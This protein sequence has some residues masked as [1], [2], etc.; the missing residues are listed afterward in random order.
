M[1]NIYDQIFHNAYWELGDGASDEERTNHAKEVMG[2]AWNADQNAYNE[3]NSN[4]SWLQNQQQNEQLTQKLNLERL[5]RWNN[6]YGN[7]GERNEEKSLKDLYEEFYS[8]N[9]KD[10]DTS[11]PIGQD[12]TAG[13]PEVHSLGSFRDETSDIRNK[14]TNNQNESTSSI[15]NENQSHMSEDVNRRRYMEGSDID[16]ARTLRWEK[17]NDVALKNMIDRGGDSAQLASEIGKLNYNDDGSFNVEWTPEDQMTDRAKQFM[18]DKGHDLKFYYDPDAGGM[19]SADDVM[20]YLDEVTKA[21][22]DYYNTLGIQNGGQSNYWAGN[23]LSTQDR[24]NQLYQ[25]FR[26]PSNN[27]GGYGD[28]WKSLERQGG[29]TEHYGDEGARMYNDQD[30][31]WFQQGYHPDTKQIY[32]SL[33]ASGITKGNPYQSLEEYQNEHLREQPVDPTDIFYSQEPNQGPNAVVKNFT[34]GSTKSLNDLSYWLTHNTM[35]SPLNNGQNDFKTLLSRSLQNGKSST[36]NK[37]LGQYKEAS[38]SDKVDDKTKALAQTMNEKVDRNQAMLNTIMMAANMAQEGEKSF[39]N[40][41]DSSVEPS[42]NIDNIVR[43]FMNYTPANQNSNLGYNIYENSNNIKPNNYSEMD[44][45]SLIKAF[46][47]LNGNQLEEDNSNSLL[48]IGALQE[49]IRRAK[50]RK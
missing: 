39:F 10:I 31:L 25:S 48:N 18:K 14:W 32:D 11:N 40:P 35:T 30:W 27:Y 5:K 13:L 16:K 36:V 20:P 50:R 19:T 29:D 17:A 41:D 43:Q 42:G 47:Q 4:D 49:A 38:N 44:T 7:P 26:G 37:L 1:A 21:M 46:N 34:N 22:S 3:N 33:N 28:K 15:N 24:D 12:M 6:F 23:G 2:A 8:G 9:K 45:N